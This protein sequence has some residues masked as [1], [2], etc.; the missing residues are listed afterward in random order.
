MSPSI[1]DLF[2]PTIYLK[3]STIYK[4]AGA[5]IPR[6]ILLEGPPG[7]GKTSFFK[8]LANRLKRHVV[9]LSFKLI[10]KKKQLQDFYFE[11]R[12]NYNNQENDI[13]FD[14]KIINEIERELEAQLDVL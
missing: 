10:T 9:S 5:E 12:Y 13:S 3:N 2:S 1:L 4:N 14:K 7:T 6:G 11:T 8:A